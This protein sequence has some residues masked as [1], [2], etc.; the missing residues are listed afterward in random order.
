MR[1]FIQMRFT[2]GARWTL[3]AM[4]VIAMH[5][6]AGAAALWKV[7]VLLTEVDAAGA[8]VV[9]LA[10]EPV[11]RADITPALPP[12]PDQV[13]GASTPDQR[14]DVTPERPHR[15]AEV[16]EPVTPKLDPPPPSDRA[17]VALPVAAPQPVAMQQ[18]NSIAN[19]GAETTSAVQVEADQRA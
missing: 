2:G 16:I 10:A 15:P 5:A 13:Q 8:M 7:P 1:R 12:G 19:Q 9:E 4:V 14:S 11:A 3:C 6:A 17:E 18:P